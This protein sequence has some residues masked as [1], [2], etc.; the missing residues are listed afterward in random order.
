MRR[1]GAIGSWTAGLA[2]TALTAGGCAPSLASPG[3]AAP[4]SA[5]QPSVVLSGS[6]STA[7]PPTAAGVADP[8]PTVSSPAGALAQTASS[9]SGFSAQPDRPTT[10]SVASTAPAG[11]GP[12]VWAA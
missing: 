4:P 6:A 9:L 11:S 12:N 3:I 1:L 7:G 8:T 5:G 10:P 2:L